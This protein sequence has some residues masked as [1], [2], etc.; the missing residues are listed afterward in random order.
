MADARTFIKVHDGL[1]EHPKIEALS[2]R[3]FRH[4]ITLW[5]YCSRNLTDGFISER[6]W[7]RITNPRTARELIEVGLVTDATSSSYS[8][9][10]MGRDHSVTTARGYW[11]HDYLDH[12]RSRAEVEDL[13]EKRRSAGRKGGKARA[14]SQPTSQANASASATA[15]GKQNGSRAEQSRFSPPPPSSNEPPAPA[16]SPANAAER[17]TTPTGHNPARQLA[18][19]LLGIDSNDPR[20]DRLPDIL[21][22]NNVRAPAAWLRATAQAGDLAPLIDAPPDPEPDPWAHLKP[23][24]PIPDGTPMPEELRRVVNAHIRRP[25][26]T[27][28]RKDTP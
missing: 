24:E 19:T 13:T 18:A 26:T 5:C 22:A 7:K 23:P 20:L 1:D 4:L 3:A 2:D 11:M 27:P 12:Q 9:V 8:P 10:T 25:A 28:T 15:S 16:E 14:S 6:T 17:E 21:R